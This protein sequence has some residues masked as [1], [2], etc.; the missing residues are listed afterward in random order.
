MTHPLRS[1]HLL[2]ILAPKPDGTPTPWR[3]S[4]EGRT[5]ERDEDENTAVSVAGEATAVGEDTFADAD[6]TLNA[7]DYG[8]YSITRGSRPS[9]PPAPRESGTGARDAF[10]TSSARIVCREREEVPDATY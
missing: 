8:P 3:L 5:M 4:L 10:A 1:F 6:V 7:R 2:S 9:Q